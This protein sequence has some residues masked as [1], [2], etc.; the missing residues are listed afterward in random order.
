MPIN[1]Q[2]VA[3]V[4]DDELMSF[5]S[6]FIEIPFYPLLSDLRFYFPVGHY[7]GFVTMARIIVVR[8]KSMC[9]PPVARTLKTRK[10]HNSL[11]WFRLLSPTSSSIVIFM[12][13]NAHW[14]LQRWK[15]REF[16]RGSVGAIL[17]FLGVFPQ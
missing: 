1:T 15:S 6:E 2:R 11:S 12:L 7:C 3:L 10:G 16:G 9:G 5:T 17:V 13:R 14:G 8:P 4:V